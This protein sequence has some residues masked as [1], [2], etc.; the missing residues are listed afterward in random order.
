MMTESAGMRIAL[1]TTLAGITAGLLLGIQYR[2][3]ERGAD[4]LEYHCRVNGSNFRL[5]EVNQS[6]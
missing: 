2:I 6:D 3:A 1:F 4:A 5:P